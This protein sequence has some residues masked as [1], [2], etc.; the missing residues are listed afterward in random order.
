MREGEFRLGVYLAHRAALIEYAT[1]F[2]GSREAAEDIV[3]D[4]YLR[5]APAK[6]S[7]GSPEQALAYL[8]RIVRNLAFDVLK[9]RKIEQRQAEDAVPFW[10]V[11]YAEPTPEQSVT[12]SE[13]IRIVSETLSSLPVEVRVA[14]EMNRFGG[15]TLEEVAEHLGVSVATVHRHIRSAMVKIASRLDGDA[16]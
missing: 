13:Q 14:V 8:Y 11:P 10:A 4:A 16:V 3:Q 15:F 9:R 1:P 2:L 6:T 5:F 7:I 12:C